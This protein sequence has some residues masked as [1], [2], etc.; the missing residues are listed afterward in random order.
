[1]QSLA[2]LKCNHWTLLYTCLINTT[3]G[4]SSQSWVHSVCSFTH[5][6]LMA[7]VVVRHGFCAQY[8]IEQ[9]ADPFT[10]DRVQHRSAIHYA[11]AKGKT[12]ALQKLL[13][14]HLCIHTD[15]G[16]VPLKNARIQDVSGNCRYPGSSACLFGNSHARPMLFTT[17]FYHAQTTPLHS[18]NKLSLLFASWHVMHDIG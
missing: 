6:L 10:Q 8:L 13:S 11:A 17:C 15:E 9:G 4:T 2:A 7:S 3:R 5:V 18:L 12:G 1:M 16:F 14:D